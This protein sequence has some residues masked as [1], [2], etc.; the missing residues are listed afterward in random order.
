MTSARHSH[1]LNRH[2]FIAD[3]LDLIRRLDNDSIDLICT[4][5]PCKKRRTFV[6]RVKP[7]LTDAELE[8]E[9]DTLA[10]WGINT[11]QQA[12]IATSSLNMHIALDPHQIIHHP[13]STPRH[14]L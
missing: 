11:P 10:G 12:L 8:A 5:P 14:L 1:P 7:P 9:Q 13:A 6:G 2:L 4:D 3:N